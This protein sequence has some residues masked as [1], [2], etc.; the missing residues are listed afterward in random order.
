MKGQ[1]LEI[2]KQRRR[3]IAQREGKELFKIFHN[4]VLEAT[5]E[6]LPKTKEELAEIKGWGKKKIEKYGDE[7]IAIINGQKEEKIKEDKILSVQELLSYLKSVFS[8]IGMVKVRGEIIEVNSHPNGYC[9]FTIKDSQTEEHSM[10]CY[11]SRWKLDSLSHL[12]EVGMEVVVRA[13]PSLYKNGRFSLTVDAVEPYGEGA[14]KKAFEA[15]KKKLE[16]KGYFDPA[17]KR[18][19]PEFIRKIGL[20]TSESGAAIRDFRKN[21]GEYGFEIYFIDVRVEGDFAEQSIISAIKW[22]NKNL[23]KL[24][25]LILTRGGGGLE[26]L[27]AFNS[28]GIAEAVML[29]RLPIITGIGHERDETIA[30]CVADKRFSTPTAVAV[31]M[32]TRREQLIDRVKVYSEN[33]TALVS[34]ILDNEKEYISAKSDELKS[35]FYNVLERYKLVLSKIAEQMH[36]GLNRIFKEFKILEQSFL[37]LIYHY[38]SAAKNQL[39]GIDIAVQRCLNLSERMFDLA[40][41]RLKTAEATLLSLNPEAILRRGYSIAYRGDKHI[42]KEVKDTKIGEKVFVKLYKGS[43]SSRVEKVEN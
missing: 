15:L 25:V 39:H 9:F 13:I 8:S 21:L 40:R 43:I 32:K 33:L 31:F 26:E 3:E 28:E 4:S 37:R 29:S 20:I 22:F 36:N 12:L 24:D 16:A 27:K 19:I 14:L 42:L 10:S 38:E 35:T 1:I 34:E 11:V 23:P 6:A 41:G 18:S 17:R 5:A 2:L 7:I 30:D